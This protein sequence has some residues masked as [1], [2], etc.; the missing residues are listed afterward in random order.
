[1]NLSAAAG[2]SLAVATKPAFHC[3]HFDEVLYGRFFLCFEKIPHACFSIFEVSMDH[4]G[5]AFCIAFYW[6]CIH[7]WR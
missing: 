3:L 7:R 6:G 1:M 4:E 2:T 5:T